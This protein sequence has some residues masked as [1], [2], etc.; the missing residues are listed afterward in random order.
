MSRREQLLDLLVTR[1]TASRDRLQ[2]LST[3][4]LGEALSK[5]L[6]AEIHAEVMHSPEI[7]AR[8]QEIDKINAEILSGNFFFRHQDLRDSIANRRMICEYA[9]SPSDDGVVGSYR[10]DEA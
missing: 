4:E 5:S 1:T 10:L 3:D 6:L 7:L 8:Q 2:R 9:L